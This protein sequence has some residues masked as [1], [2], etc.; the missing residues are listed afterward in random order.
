MLV[1]EGLNHCVYG[2]SRV[3]YACATLYGVGMM[4]SYR[5]S[6]LSKCQLF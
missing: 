1:V 4:G 2:S 6:H 3:K 5:L